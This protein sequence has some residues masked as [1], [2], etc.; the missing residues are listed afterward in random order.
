MSVAAVQTARTEGPIYLGIFALGFV[1]DILCRLYPAQLPFWMPWE[2]SWTVYLAT[3]LSLLWFWRGWRAGVRITRWRAASFV[4]GILSFYVVLQTH[5]DYWA[6]HMF[7]VHRWA[8]FVLHH[9]GAFLIGLGMSGPVLFAGMPEFL[10][11]LVM[12]RPVR[13]ILNFLQHPVIAP[14]LFVGLL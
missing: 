2:F 12:A 10:Q 3:A 13:A 4:L 6:Q 14:F 8:H 7:F 9:A 11:P 5:I 1:L